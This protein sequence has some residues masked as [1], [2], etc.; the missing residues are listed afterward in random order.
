MFE[1]T[2]LLSSKGRYETTRSHLDA[3]RERNRDSG[4]VD[5]RAERQQSV[6]RA[7]VQRLWD[8]RRRNRRQRTAS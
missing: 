1:H 6:R 7:T 2:S 8:E 3:V 5:R 4:P